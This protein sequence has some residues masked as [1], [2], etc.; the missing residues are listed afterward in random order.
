[1]TDPRS[2][3]SLAARRG[4]GA[5]DAA[6]RP[7][8]PHSHHRRRFRPKKH[9]TQGWTTASFHFSM[10]ATF[11]AIG[12]VWSITP[13]SW[14][15][16]LYTLVTLIPGA[17]SARPAPAS[18]SSALHALHYAC[19]AYCSLECLFSI[20]Y[21][22]QAIRCNRL[23]PAPRHS[24]KY[25]RGLFLRSL[26]NG[27]LLD[28]EHDSG[29]E[30]AEVVVEK[31]TRA[32]GTEKLEDEWAEHA[33]DEEEATRGSDSE[34]PAAIVAAKRR[35][36][37]GVGDGA[38]TPE[39][40]TT[41]LP[42]SSGS[43]GSSDYL[44]A[45]V[46]P[47][48]RTDAA[49]AVHRSPSAASRLQPTQSRASLDSRDEGFGDISRLS[50]R[51]LDSAMGAS[52]RSTTG[53]VLPL[54][55]PSAP[56]P[57]PSHI[58][59]HKHKHPDGHA[60]PH[61]R[62]LPRLAPTDPRAVE[63]RELLRFWFGGCEFAQIGRLNMADWLAWSMYG[64]PLET[65]EEE[66]R[67]WDKKGRP[68]LYCRDGVTVDADSE[69]DDS[70]DEDE[71]EERVRARR[72]R[73]EESVAADRL[74]LVHHC[75][76]L[77]EARAAHV[78]PPG[79]NPAVKP[80][81]LTLDPLRVT[82]RPL[83]LY[84]VVNLLQK[85]VMGRALTRGFKK[86]EDG[87]TRY[88]VRVPEGWEPRPDL[89]EDERPLV[90]IHGL[91][92]GLAQYTTL[93]GVLAK[94][95]ALRRRP[96]LVLLQPHISM[97]LFSRGFLDPV[98][99]EQCAAG[100][101]R[102]LRKHGFDERAGGCTVL[103]HSN[104]TIVHGW[105]L[106]HQPQLVARSCFVDPVAFQLYEPWVCYNALYARAKKPMEHL[107]RYFVM[108]ELGVAFMLSRTFSWTANLLWPSEIPHNADAHKTAVFL[109]SEDSILAAERVRVYLRRSGLRE[110]RAPRRVGDEPG[111][112]GL[113][114]FQ[115]LKHGESMIGEGEPF[116]EVLRW[117]TWDGRDPTA[118]ETGASSSSSSSDGS[119]EPEA[120]PAP[121]AT[122]PSA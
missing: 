30:D 84:V 38:L 118:Y 68:P 58:H 25:L 94:S 66:R 80:L 72:T 40:G 106:K 57:A 95:R 33:R 53:P 65:L 120:P 93:V 116:E 78:F 32:T 27:L 47:P 85:A 102:V 69:L 73:T 41:D 82:S 64:E 104:G 49:P 43:G 17:R 16:V 111:G 44:S 113:K 54:V 6:A 21:R 23:R 11:L 114:V 86:C 37:P 52:P 91:G 31:A 61:T 13:L 67:E 63:F 20:Y 22:A 7:R 96:I 3:P 39:L 89:H 92:M 119:E 87:D 90:F 35:R 29:D 56:S 19:L 62:F 34:L 4:Q 103:S 28:D 8:R 99:Q 46:V 110:V 9:F 10:A 5:L 107:M 108:R 18:S 24:R 70:D 115:G 98:E 48:L 81:R 51:T 71:V 122:A 45:R 101:E 55:A 26:E 77:V 75:L 50:L 76:V 88:L 74:G 112:G 42:T 97:S 12:A 109:A 79:R 100:L 121:A 117:V 1:M 105:L 59:A 14:G 60:H 36:R 15:Y 2:T 83:L